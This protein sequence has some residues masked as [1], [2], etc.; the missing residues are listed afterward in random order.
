MIRGQ[1]VEYAEQKRAAELVIIQLPETN[2]ND[3]QDFRLA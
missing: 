3:L 1:P 2:E